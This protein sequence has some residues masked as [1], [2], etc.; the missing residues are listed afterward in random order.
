MLSIKW[1]VGEPI[2][3]GKIRVALDG[4]V[5]TSVA[6]RLVVVLGQVNWIGGIDNYAFNVLFGTLQPPYSYLK[7]ILLCVPL[8]QESPKFIEI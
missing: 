6:N 4:A 2:D 5:F 7:S 3:G 1:R 8:A